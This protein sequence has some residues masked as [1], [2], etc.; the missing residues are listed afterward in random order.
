MRSVD[1]KE[2]LESECAY[3]VYRVVY[4]LNPDL[5][6]GIEETDIRRGRRGEENVAIVVAVPETMNEVVS[7][8][9]KTRK[10]R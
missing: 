1:L 9:I 3:P 4:I 8:F 6:L 10:N 5:P 2:D 7:D